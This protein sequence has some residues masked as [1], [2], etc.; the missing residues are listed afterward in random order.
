MTFGHAES[1]SKWLAEFV[2]RPDVFAI[3]VGSNEGESAEWLL[4]HILTGEG[5]E[6]L[7]LDC[8]CDKVNDGRT[9]ALVAE[10]A[11]D[12]RMAPFGTRITKVKGWSAAWVPFLPQGYQFAYIDASHDAV[13]VIEDSVLVWPHLSPGGVLIWDDY[14][15]RL[16][17]TERDCPR[18]A[19]DAFCGIYGNQLDLLDPPGWQVAVKKR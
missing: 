17:A 14:D 8:W 19:I 6:L 9:S 18:L 12:R 2:G 7:C 3:E 15:W 16:G 11:F 5:S 1:W 13:S 10:R 4:Q